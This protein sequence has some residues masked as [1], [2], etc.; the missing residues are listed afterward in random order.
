M[1]KEIHM[2]NDE[3]EIHRHICIWYRDE[4]CAEHWF[5]PRLPGVAP[6]DST[7]S[8]YYY[9]DIISTIGT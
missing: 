6:K 7:A 3:R 5:E 2:G 8:T 1:D 4:I 9:R